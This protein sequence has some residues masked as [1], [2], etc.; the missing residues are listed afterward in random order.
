MDVQ[1]K[2][3]IAV[4]PWLAYGHIIP[5]LE[6][7]KFLAQMGHRVLYI[8]T[9]K[10]ISRLPKLPSEFSPNLCFIELPLPHVQG[11]PQ[12]VESTADLPIQKVPFL[13]KAYDKLQGPLG[14][15]LET[16]R[17]D[18]II[19]DF[20]PYWLPPLAAQLG[21]NL[22]FFS[23]VG[24]SSVAFIGPPDK[25]IAARR[26]RRAEDLTVIPEWIDYPSN[27]AFK[28]HEVLSH[29]QCE[30]QDAEGFFR[31]GS[32]VQ[33]CQVVTLRSCPEFEPDPFN[34]LGK[35]LQKPVVPIGLLPPSV[36]PLDGVANGDE[37]WVA[38]KK[39]LDGMKEKSV[40]YVALGT[41]VTLSPEQS[42][43]LASGVEKSGLPFI[44]VV[45]NR[46]LVEGQMGLHIFP[47]GFE[48]RVS[49][50]GVVVRGWA[51][52]MRILA[53]PSIGGF[54]THCGWSSTIEALSLGLPLILF[55]GASSD[56][57]LV[58]RLLHGKRVG[59]EIERNEVDGSFTSDTVAK[60]IRVVMEEE[61]GEPI[62]ANA[63]AMKEICGNIELGKKHLT[64][65][66]RF[67]ENYK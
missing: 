26:Q 37:T 23:I 8:S 19:H 41:E 43:E 60:V 34:L 1:S 61:E 46:P 21:I 44:W 38:L 10:N 52:Q 49:E 13:K 32:V 48:E 56:L 12:G 28:L 30:D 57:G 17:V 59:L 63:W 39:W 14:E 33:G 40:F 25:L 29:Q 3:H 7:S 36:P 35:I 6:V 54:L 45:K 22:A 4:F 5:F 50:R 64:Q 27:V 31:W 42:H 47:Q 51:P 67:L 20:A 16:S 66:V 15:F 9:P 24:A 11:L 58:A 65:F 62:R 2:L 18:W 53:H 55:S